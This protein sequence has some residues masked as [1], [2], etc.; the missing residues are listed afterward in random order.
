VPQIFKDLSVILFQD[1]LKLVFLLILLQAYL[2][3]FSLH[4]SA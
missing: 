3:T 2:L 1:F 4:N